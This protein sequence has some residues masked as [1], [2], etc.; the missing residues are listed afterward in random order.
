MMQ[1]YISPL[2][3]ISSLNNSIVLNLSVLKRIT[4]GF[5]IFCCWQTFS[6]TT[7]S[8]FSENK[9]SIEVG[10]SPSA[11]VTPT[12]G[13]THD[14]YVVGYFA[15]WAI[16]T[17][18]FN[19]SDIEAEHLTHLMY[20]FYDVKF[21]DDDSGTVSLTTLDPWADFGHT[22]DPGV[23]YG[24]NPKGNFG[25][26]KVLK[27]ENPHLNIL[28]SIG[29]WTRSIDIPAIANDPV[30]T[31]MLVQQMVN[32]MRRFP[33]IDGFDVDWEFPIAGGISAEESRYG[34]QP[35]YD[36]DHTNLVL[37]LKAMREGFDEA[38]PDNRKWVTMAGGNNVGNLL[39]THVGPGT[40]S[41]QGAT[42]NLADYADFITFFGYDFGGNWFEKTSYN[43]P[44]YPS[45]NPEDP[46]IRRRA[47]EAPTEVVSS[48][49]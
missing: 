37:L 26:L 6:H 41:L 18:D 33:F 3:L 7:K 42:E 47:E 11:V 32:L 49:N 45:Y 39:S 12:T 4:F 25:A 48:A 28:M 35:H 15:Q 34:E 9:V 31:D 10:H 22:E 17:R 30:K 27:M 14:K 20:A 16:Y 29:G 43:A 5:L 8:I 23:L 2:A 36:N 19:V 1:N 44:L 21:E 13:P 46:L 38:F 40:E 24:S